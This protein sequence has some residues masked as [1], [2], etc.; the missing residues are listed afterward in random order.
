MEQAEQLI[1]ERGLPEPRYIFATH[2]EMAHCGGSGLIIDRWPDVTV[3]GD[4]SDLHLV[5]P[6]YDG[7]F[8]FAEPGDRFDLGGTEI[9]VNES[10]FRDLVHSRWYFDTSRRALFPGDG[11][12]YAHHHREGAC[13]R[14]AEE[15]PMDIGGQMAFF[16]RVAFQW[17]AY[18]DIE[19]FIVRLNELLF[20]ELDVQL[21]CPTHGLPI[22]DPKATMPVVEDGLRG[23]GRVA[24][25]DFD[26]D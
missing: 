25:I 19:P 2:S 11:F 21:V 15:V 12:A 10:V 18:V 22:S 7:K 20:D 5:F 23:M 13:G 16:A 14:F 17:T 26:D 6:Q 8:H 1:A 4:V 24:T 9:V 3:H